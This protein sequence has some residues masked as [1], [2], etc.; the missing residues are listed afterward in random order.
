MK[1]LRVS[2]L[3]LTAFILCSNSLKANP[4]G[5]TFFSELVFDSTGWKLEM[6]LNQTFFNQQGDSLS[7][8]GWYIVSGKDTAYFKDWMYLRPYHGSYSG[9]NYL[10]LTKDSLNG[11]LDLNMA[12]DTLFLYSPDGKQWDHLQYGKNGLLAPKLNQSICLSY[13][14]FYLDNSPT[15]GAPNDSEGA[16]ATIKGFVKDAAG[17]PAVNYRFVYDGNHM[18]FYSTDSTGHFK[19]ENWLASNY[20]FYFANGTRHKYLSV[21]LQPGEIK[22]VEF[23]LDWLTAVEKKTAAVVVKEYSLS[24]NYPNPFNPTTSISYSIA[25][26]GPVKLQVYNLLG[27]E[28]ATIVNEHKN[29]GVHKASFDASMLPSGVYIYIIQAGE[30]R[31]GKKMTVLK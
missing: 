11:S 17:N 7:L 21:S 29:A 30:F 10:V 9:T 19:F 15:I 27:N 8:K 16:T 28:I 4:I 12:G 26:A 3:L 2:F 14:F 6:N 13:N 23:Q 25:K 18:E 22:E 31:S 1:R 24:Q 5:F 20:S